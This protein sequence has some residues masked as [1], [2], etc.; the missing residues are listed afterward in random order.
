[1]LLEALLQAA[2]LPN[3]SKLFPWNHRLFVP[4]SPI[5]F[6]SKHI[7]QTSGW[8]CW[9]TCGT[10]LNVSNVPRRRMPE[11]S[12]QIDKFD[13]WWNWGT[14]NTC[15]RNDYIIILAIKCKIKC[16]LIHKYNKASLRIALIL[17][18]PTEFP[19]YPQNILFQN[20]A[21]RNWVS[22]ICGGK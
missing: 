19:K 17:F 22:S 13:C 3:S 6:R 7:H 8:A 4:T 14:P 9:A 16:Q 2:R 21:T 10:H 5:N 1:M 12:K 20:L 15:P 11:K 18:G